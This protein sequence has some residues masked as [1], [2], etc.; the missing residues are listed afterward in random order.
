VNGVPVLNPRVLFEDTNRPLVVVAAMVTHEIAGALDEKRI[1]HLFAERDGSVGFFPGHWLH[2]HRSEFERLYS[3][4]ADDESRV[5]LMAAAKGRVFQQYRFLMQGNLFLRDLATFPQYFREEIFTFCGPELLVDCG[6]FDGDTLVA[7]F[8]LMERLGRVD[9]RA[10]AL[11]VDGDNMRSVLRTLERYALT[12]VEVIEAAVGREDVAGDAS[13]FYNCREGVDV[14][15]V[16]VVT[17]DCVLDGKAPTF[18]KMD[19][20]GAELDGLAGARRTISRFHPKLAICMYHETRHLVEVPS[21]V[22][23]NHP[24]YRVFMRHHAPGSL[25]ETVCYATV[26]Q[27]A[28][29]A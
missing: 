18:L 28:I 14:R 11:E 23:D 24:E 16:R 2:R 5:V 21:Y 26:D 17:L 10:V 1:P 29:H 15:Q 9:S 4:L 13:D 3:S 20:E 8:S 27:P 19:I 22:L 6:A 12:D 25:W 7:F